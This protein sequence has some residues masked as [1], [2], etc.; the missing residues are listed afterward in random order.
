MITELMKEFRE[1]I[2]EL[3]DLLDADLL[4]KKEERYIRVILAKEQRRIS[5]MAIGVTE[6]E[7]MASAMDMMKKLF[8]KE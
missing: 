3:E 5:A 4:T 7:M 1:K 2:D 6:E 8:K